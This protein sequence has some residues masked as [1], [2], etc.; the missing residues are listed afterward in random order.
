MR[1]SDCFHGQGWLRLAAMWLLTLGAVTVA[2]RPA[3]AVE[4]DTFIEVVTEDD[5]LQLLENGDIEPETYE[6]LL[7][8]MTSGID[9]NRADRDEL[10]A[11]PNLSLADAEAIMAYREQVGRIADPADLVAAGVLSQRQLLAMAAFLVVTEPGLRV[12]LHG[13]ARL[14]ALGVVGDARTPPLALDARARAWGKL[15]VGAA[16]T[17]VRNRLGRVRYDA[18]RD[19]LVAGAPSPHVEVPKYFAAWKDERWGMIGG[20]YRTGFAERLMFDTTGRERPQGWVPDLTLSRESELSLKCKESSGELSVSPCSGTAGYVYTVP[21]FTWSELLRGVAGYVV[22]GDGPVPP[23]TLHAFASFQR[24][25]LYQYELFD[26]SACPDPREDDD[27]ACD[28]PRVLNLDPSDPFA[29]ASAWKLSTLPD[30]FD[31]GI[32]GGYVELRPVSHWRVGFGGYGAQVRWLVADAEL[33]FQEWS[34]RP[35]G[36]AYGAV[37]AFVGWVKG[38]SDLGLELARSFDGQPTG[39]G[40]AALLRETLSWDEHELELVLRFYDPDYANPYARA[41]AAADE[42]EGLRVRNEA[43]GRLKYTAEWFDR[44]E[45]RARL[46]LWREIETRV[47]KLDFAL[48]SDVEVFRWWTPGL[49]L[50]YDDKNLRAGGAGQCF[51]VP[52]Q[53]DVEGEPIPCAGNRVAVTWRSRLEPHA[54]LSVTLVARQAWLDDPAVRG[55]RRDLATWLTL[56]T[57]PVE[58]LRLSSR[59][60]YDDESLGYP[61]RGQTLV[62]WRFDTNVVLAKFLAAGVGYDLRAF[63]DERESTSVRTPHPEHWLRAELSGKF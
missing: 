55:K 4:F 30:L 49:W 54:R 7:D 5:L 20:T 16:A 3:A 53:E 24:H 6:E 19:A 18:N 45:L 46:D 59:I 41:V 43:G 37:G 47:P 39:G 15:D 35:Y 31:E 23:A 42:D 22:L 32:G 52:D 14:R 29:P 21:D 12:P 36:G 40:Y 60:R 63:V 13:K 11:L 9:L 28:A 57:R 33:D 38:L 27:P 58:R 17:L 1:I 51:E 2:I 56:R 26:P 50:D 61:E 34:R 25:R 62:W 44:L 48:R 10:Y 8:L